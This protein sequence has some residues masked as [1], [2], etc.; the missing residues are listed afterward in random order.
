VTVYY[1]FNKKIKKFIKFTIIIVFVL[2]ILFLILS[3]FINMNTLLF[4]FLSSFH[5]EDISGHLRMRLFAI[6]LF[7]KKPLFG[8]GIGGYGLYVG[9]IDMSIAHSQF[10][11]E[12]C[13]G[14]IVGF[15]IFL[16]FIVYCLILPLIHQ[17]RS[18]PK[19]DTLYRAILIGLIGAI[20]LVIVNNIAL[21]NTLYRET[22][23]MLFALSIA[24]SNIKSNQIEIKE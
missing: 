8:V 3:Q 10:L 12:L 13:E 9:Q 24:A 1:V 4:R 21:Y 17:L 19:Q 18:C 22:N 20:F 23:W 15:I 7:L 14:G 5:E 2:F 6:E 16:I 11:L